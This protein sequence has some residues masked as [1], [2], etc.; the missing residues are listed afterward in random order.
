MRSL[1]ILAVISMPFLGAC[2]W[3]SHSASE[4]PQKPVQRLYGELLQQNNRLWLRTCDADTPPKALRLDTSAAAFFQAL[5]TSGIEGSPLF[6]DLSA[7]PSENA[8]TPLQVSHFYRISQK[9]TCPAPDFKRLILQAN[10]HSPE[11]HMKIMPQGFLLERAGQPALA[12]PYVEEQLGNS[13][14]EFSSEA[15][16]KRIRL[17]IA[18]ELCIDSQMVSGYPLRARLTIDNEPLRT[19]CASFG[20]ARNE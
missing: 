9:K 11:W 10:G 6:A 12:L 4:L 3:W 19:G 17:Y 2:Q 5:R 14:Y 8:A 20:G 16:G 7:V 1:T 18:P 13:A 15:N